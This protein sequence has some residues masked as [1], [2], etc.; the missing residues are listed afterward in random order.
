MDGRVRRGIAL[1]MAGIALAAAVPSHAAPTEPV[2]IGILDMR[3]SKI[4]DGDANVKIVY[5]EFSQPGAIAG[6]RSTPS[7][8]DHGMIVA[9]SAVR[10]VR[11]IDRSVP[12]EIYAANA[13]RMSPD[14]KSYSMDYG[15]AMEAIDWMHAQ[16]VRV[17]V[18]SY[19]TK[20]MGG[21][22]SLMNRAENLGMTVVAGA[23]NVAGAGKV[24]PAADPRA[25]SVA[26]T[27]PNGSSLTLD[28]SVQQWVKFGFRGDYAD[29]SRGGVVED[30]GSS[31]SSA[32]VGGVAAYYQSRNP[33]AGRGEI[34][35]MLAGVARPQMQKY[36]KVKATIA[37]VDAGGYAGR[38]R[39]FADAGFGTATLMARAG[40]AVAPYTGAKGPA[41]AVNDA[42]AQLPPALSAGRDR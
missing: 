30:W 5:R 7:G 21:A 29:R 3:A 33:Q 16:G 35:G 25:I 28:P 18:T 2:R 6:S 4:A 11:E 37:A 19:N 38:V 12:I 10:A 36:G 1:G 20:N 41:M 31:Y 15:K 40:A 22:M 9:T 13:F 32:K 8:L 27:T 42:V 14:G 23:S 34:E 17:V 24:W 39:E 26:D